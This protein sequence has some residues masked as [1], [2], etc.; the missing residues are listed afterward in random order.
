MLGDEVEV[1]VGLL[2]GDVLA[3]AEAEVVGFD[4]VTEGHEVV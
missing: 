4:A 3:P 1:A 2:V